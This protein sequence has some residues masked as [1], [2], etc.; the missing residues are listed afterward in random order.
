MIADGVREKLQNII[1][2]A[3]LQG[4]RDRCSTIRN[5]LIESFGANPTVKSEFE[6]RAII[7]EKQAGFLRSYAK[8]RT[9]G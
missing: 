7:K 4:A 3:R 6:N 9:Y 2:G 5:I 1:R 8:T